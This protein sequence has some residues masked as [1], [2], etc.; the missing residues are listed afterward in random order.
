MTLP[1]GKRWTLF[2]HILTPSWT[3]LD[4]IRRRVA[5]AA[6]IVAVGFVTTLSLLPSFA[7]PGDY[8]LDKLLHAA[9][10]AILALLPHAAFEK[11]H[12]ALAAAFAMI[13]LGCAIEVAQG[14]VPGRYGDVWD[15]LAN[16]SGVFAGVAFGA[17]FR[18]IVAAIPFAARRMER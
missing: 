5:L 17:S 12:V 13:P 16:S 2:N 15:A 8:G 18:Q 7:P 14:F 10:Y 9:G 4:K 6:W 3:A 1:R 11:R